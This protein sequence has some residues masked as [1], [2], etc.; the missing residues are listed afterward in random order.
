MRH[1][2]EKHDFPIRPLCIRIISKGV[3]YF[4]QRHFFSCSLFI[5]FPNY[6]VSLHH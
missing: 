5:S 3:K 1:S 2:I 6:P 4:F